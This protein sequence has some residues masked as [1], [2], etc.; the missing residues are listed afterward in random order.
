MIE[1]PNIKT[2]LSGLKKF[3][4]EFNKQLHN[5]AAGPIND[6]LKQWAARYKSFVQLRFDKHSKGGGDWPT[7]SP[8]T[9]A[10]R[11]QGSSTI[12]RDTNTMF[13]VLNPTFT[14]QPGATEER[15]PGGIRIGFGGTS[16]YPSGGAAT[17]A[18][19]ASFHHFGRGVLPERKI[20]VPAPSAVINQMIGDA[21]RAA[22]ELRRGVQ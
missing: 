22:E 8:F 2:N 19:I 21:G 16:R 18:D 6:M 3:G 14:N 5:G 20:L 10:Q 15:I 9:I 12:L 13:A 17:I 4:A 11:R 1:E 7:L